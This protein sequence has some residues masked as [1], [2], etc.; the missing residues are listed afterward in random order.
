MDE[1]DDTFLWDGLDEFETDPDDLWLNHVMDEYEADQAPIVQHG[2]GLT[3]AQLAAHVT[4]TPDGS[5]RSPKFGYVFDRFEL[6]TH[7]LENM[8]PSDVPFFIHKMLKHVMDFVTRTARPA[9]RIR[10]CIDAKSLNYPIWTSPIRRDQL[11]VDRWWLSVS[12]SFR[13]PQTLRTFLIASKQAYMKHWSVCHFFRL[14]THWI[15]M[16]RFGWTINSKCPSRLPT[17]LLEGAVIRMR[18]QRCCSE[19]C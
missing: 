3:E 1:N 11:T 8:P 4:I 18:S 6:T 10:L 15:L 19:S 5:R 12:L 14:R 7:D 2:E 13:C 17:F 16:K 9:D